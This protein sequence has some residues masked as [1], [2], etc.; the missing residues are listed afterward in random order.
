MWHRVE[1]SKASGES[2]LSIGASVFHFYP[3]MYALNF[4][5]FAFVIIPNLIWEAL[6]LN[7]E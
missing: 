1:Y 7:V 5:L 4:P 3:K 2:N 6:G